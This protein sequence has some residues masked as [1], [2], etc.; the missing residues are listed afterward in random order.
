MVFTPDLHQNGCHPQKLSASQ[1]AGGKTQ[2]RAFTNVMKLGIILK[3]TANPHQLANT[4]GQKLRAASLQALYCATYHGFF[5][6]FQ[7][8]VQHCYP[9]DVAPIAAYID[10]KLVEVVSVCGGRSLL[11]DSLARARLRL[12]ARM[13]GGGIR[14][15]ADVAPA[16]F[17]A[18]ACRALPSMLD[19]TT[20]AGTVM[21]GFLP[22]LS[23][24]LGADSFDAGMERSRF[25]A[26][27]SSGSRLGATFATCWQ[28]LSAEVGDVHDGPLAE[29]VAGAGRGVEKM[30]RALTRH[31]EAVRFQCLDVTLRGLQ[32]S[33]PRRQ[34]WQNLNRFSTVWVTSWP[35]DDALLDNGEFTEIV[36]RYFALPSPACAGP[37]G[38]TVG[39]TRRRVDAHGA[40]LTAAALPGDGRRNQHDTI[41]WRICEDLREMGVRARPEVFGLF[42]TA[43]PQTARDELGRWTTRKR[44][45]LV[46]DLLVGVPM[47]GGAADR[48]CLFELKTLHAGPSTYP[49]SS[50]ERCAAACTRAEALPKEYA[51]K[52]QRLDREFCDTPPGVVGP[53]ERRLLALGTVRGLVFGHWGETSPD[54]EDL[55][56]IAAEVGARR[57]WRAMQAP[58]P[59]VALGS[60]VWLLRRRWGM[61]AWRASARLLLDRLEHIGA[62]AATA[63]ARRATAR[64]DAVEARRAA[65]WLHR[66]GRRPRLWARRWRA[67]G[68]RGLPWSL[69][70]RFQGCFR[71][72]KISDFDARKT[73][74]T[75]EP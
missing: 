64:A 33:D 24:L 52:A 47:P 75:L 18:T 29:P 48:D 12:P 6:L 55:L 17:V 26:L 44:Q 71:D 7:Y 34:A 5:P 43:L 46:P 61:A 3:E 23:S 36:A 73:P 51:T 54:V 50:T 68:C 62:G 11:E 9:A 16:A 15:L 56:S 41:K 32:A 58:S 25:A 22:Q 27:V 35:C 65:C 2:N 20:E 14:S 70:R 67:R 59:G 42:A 31:R 63:A 57:H 40:T 39:N 21:P 28:D 4:I 66:G 8:W 10:S 53:V 69:A 19:R 49:A 60:L 13:F 74:L 72:I 30:Q 38:Q 45:G 1:R 37:V